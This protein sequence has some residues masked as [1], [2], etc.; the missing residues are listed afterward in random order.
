MMAQFARPSFVALAAA[1]LAA[2]DCQGGAP[3]PNQ[4]P[5]PPPPP[6]PPGSVALGVEQ[7]VDGLS[8]PVYLT[9]PPGDD[10]LFVVEQAGRILIIENDQLLPTPFL[11]IQS[12]VGSGGN[13]Q[14]LLSMAFHP[15]YGGNGFFYVSYTMTNGDSRVERY[16]VSADP[17]VADEDSDKEIL[18]LDQPQSNHN[19]GLLLFDEDGLLYIGLGDGGGSGDPDENGQDLGTLLGKL[20]RIDVDGGDP[21][22]IP[23]GNPFGDEIWALGLRNPWRF[24]FDETDGLLFIADVGQNEFEEVNVVPI[25]QAAVNYGWNIMEGV[26][27]FEPSTNCN[28]QGLTLPVVEYSHGEGCSITGGFVYR[29]SAIP[30]IEGHYFYSDFCSSFLRSFRFSNDD[31]EDGTEW[32]VGNLGG[33][34]SFGRDAT[35]ELYILSNDGRVLRL[36]EEQG[37]AVRNKK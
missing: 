15:D 30:E 3:F 11:D 7:V 6:P 36:V 14:G 33:V 32:D 27:C 12:I 18:T 31:V 19:G 25:D 8:R 22:A 2:I 37:N 34:L 4:P 23:P 21:Y 13:E 10:R 28:M 1:C 9:T 20:L 5:P 24:A 35:G 16:T 29:G 26:H 17:N